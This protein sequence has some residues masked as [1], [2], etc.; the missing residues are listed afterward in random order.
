M[1]LDA[2]GPRIIRASFHTKNRINMDVI[3]CYAPTND[4]D[5]EDKKDF[6]SRLLTTI[7]DCPK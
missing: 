7:Q 1:G 2:H 4:S 5:E 6:Y 3:Q